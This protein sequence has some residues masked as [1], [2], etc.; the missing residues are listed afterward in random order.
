MHTADE[1]PGH[2]F[3]IDGDLARSTYD[4]ALVA[5]LTTADYRKLWPPKHAGRGDCCWSAR[6]T[7]GLRLAVGQAGHVCG[8]HQRALQLIPGQGSTYF[9]ATR[10]RA[11]TFHSQ[12]MKPRW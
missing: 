12:G 7:N 1:V 3:I 11:T 6:G 5:T 10:L 8:C 2:L 4:A 9:W